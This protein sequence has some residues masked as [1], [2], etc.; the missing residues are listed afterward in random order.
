MAEQGGSEGGIDRRLVELAADPV[1]S[2]VLVFVGEHPGAGPARVAEALGLDPEA[3]K[4]ALDGLSDRGLVEQIAGSGAGEPGYRALSRA[5]WTDE[6]IAELSAEERQR[7]NAWIVKMV[8]AD[9]EKAMAAGTLARN[10]ETHISRTVSTVDL[11]G[12]RELTRIQDEALSA[13]FAVQEA[14]AERLAERGEEGISVLTAML[15]CQLPDE[16]GEAGGS[17]SQSGDI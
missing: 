4:A 11:E 8:G 15:C 17:V 10:V 12:W 5:L 2:G 6:E 16:P 14:A 3:A 13:V 9:V 7:L 1:R